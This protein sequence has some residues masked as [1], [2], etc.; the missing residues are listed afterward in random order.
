MNALV[1]SSTNENRQSLYLKA[2]NDFGDFRMNIVVVRR[3][4]DRLGDYKLMLLACENLFFISTAAREIIGYPFALLE[5]YTQ[6]VK[7]QTAA[8]IEAEYRRW[9]RRPHDGGELLMLKI[10]TKAQ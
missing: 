8:K 3:P 7:N 6:L 4:D 1:W 5:F 10:T 9:R 2:K